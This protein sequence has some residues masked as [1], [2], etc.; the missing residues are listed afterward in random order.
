MAKGKTLWEMLVEKLS[1][2]PLEFQVYNPLQARVGSS[3]MID[4]VEWRDLNFF[5]REIREYKRRISGKEFVF[6]DYVLRARPLRGNEVCIRLRLNPVDDPDR[7]GGLTHHVLLLQLDDDLPYSAD[8]HRVVNDTTGKFQ[9]LQDGQVR[10]EFERIGGVSSPYK[11]QVAVLRD[12]NRDEKVSQDEVERLRLEYWDYSREVKDAA[13]Q[14]QQQFL[15]VEMNT[16]NGWFQIW[17]GQEIDPQRVMV[18]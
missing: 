8:L 3:V 5:L 1:R 14:A 18:F 7:H 16:Q 10:E 9:I 13:G 4:D 6:V 11:A 2:P 12:V 15:F 17:R